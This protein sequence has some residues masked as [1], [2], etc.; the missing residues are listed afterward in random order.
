M[1]T[2]GLER[3]PVPDVQIL[4]EAIEAKHAAD[5]ALDAVVWRLNGE[6]QIR[7]GQSIDAFGY[8]TRP[9]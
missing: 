2:T 3:I 7:P 6:H 9:K 8:I 5:V 4:R 1:E